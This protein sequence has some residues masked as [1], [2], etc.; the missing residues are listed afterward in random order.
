MAHI[1]QVTG[2]IDALAERKRFQI[3]HSAQAAGAVLG[4]K[5]QIKAWL[6]PQK[7]NSCSC[8]LTSAEPTSWVLKFA[9]WH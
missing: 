1:E 9:S 3:V 6:E 7:Q 8:F 2:H 5:H 4:P